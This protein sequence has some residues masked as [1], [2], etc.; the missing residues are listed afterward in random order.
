MLNRGLLFIGSGADTETDLRPQAL[1]TDLGRAGFFTVLTPETAM[2]QWP[3][4]R[5]DIAMISPR[6]GSAA[7]LLKLCRKHGVPH[8]IIGCPRLDDEA[9]AE[10]ERYRA[11]GGR[12]LGPGSQGFFDWD[13]KLALCWSTSVRIPD[14]PPRERHV[15][16]I[17]Q[18]GSIPYSLYAMA[19]EAGVR[20]RRVVSLGNCAD[21]DSELLKAMESAIDDPM[22]TLLILSLE[23]LSQG[24][25]FLAMTAR[26]AQRKLPVVLLRIGTSDLFRQR[27]AE[28]HADAAWT[29][30]VMWE[31]VAGQYGVVLLKDAQQIVDLG[32]LSGVAGSAKGNRVAILALSEGVAM[33][34]GDQCRQSG[35]E[36]PEFSA[37][38]REKIEKLIPGWGH[39]GNPVD[40]TE[41][42]FSHEDAFL[43]ILD[44]L[45]KSDECDMILAATGSLSPRQGEILARTLGIAHRAGKKPLACCCL[46]RWHPLDEMVR[47]MNNDGVPLFS[48]PRRVAEAMASLWRIGR[49]VV[50]VTELC[51]PA[52]HPRLAAYPKRLSERDA[53]NLSTDYGLKTVPQKFC[54]SVAEV[55]DAAGTLGFPMVLKV[56][57]HSF[58][59]KQQARAVALN[60]RTEEELRN[61]YGRILERADRLH[62]DAAVEGVYAQK[63]VTDGIECMIGI[64]RDPLFG[65]VVAVALG[66]AYYGL[67]KDISLRVAPVDMDTALGM[68]RGLR[69]Y[70]I[71]S[72]KWF[73]RPSDIDSLAEQIVRLS[74]M[75]CA[76]PD[77][78][79]LDINPIFVR[80]EGCGAEIADAFAVRRRMPD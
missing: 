50:P 11:G 46:S 20:F 36:V 33:I 64:K 18:G 59:S 19:V 39:R 23:S 79:L 34:Q 9:R 17:G 4:G 70:P 30:N 43:K 41:S 53:M 62:A 51:R 56:V 14:S 49:R 8:L 75:A 42:V 60:L 61:A 72:G 12:A 54:T 22:T 80:P 16:L 2:K 57:S 24:R 38:L 35:L 6:C 5:F 29:D 67:I 15:T 77:L 55:L 74:R 3:E 25:S 47:R 10:L 21:Q 69:G 1:M 48:S 58:F 40:L 31:S 63:M 27:L 71:V 37:E 78:E 73:G 66:G 28:R 76:E 65:P 26:A 52:A 45:E 44:L 32:K 7:A 68:I 13:Q